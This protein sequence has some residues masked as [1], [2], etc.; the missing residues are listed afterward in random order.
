MIDIEV[1]KIDTDLRR[2]GTPEVSGRFNRAL[3]D[4]VNDLAEIVHSEAVRNAPLGETGELKS[5]GIILRKGNRINTSDSLATYE[6]RVELNPD[7]EHGIWVHEGTGEF[8][9]YRT[10]IV[11]THFRFMVFNIGGKWFQRTSVRGQQAQPF[12]T[13]AYEYVS[14]FSTPAKLAELRA[15]IAART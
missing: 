14:N 11:P 2:I 1:V 9:P 4:F 8:G 7:V 13:D 6:A 10:R 5:H 12:L 15:E 3:K